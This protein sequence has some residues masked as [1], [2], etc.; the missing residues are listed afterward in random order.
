MV[1]GGFRTLMI[2]DIIDESGAKI[3]IISFAS[4]FSQVFRNNVLVIG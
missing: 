3:S 4:S 1:N 2:W